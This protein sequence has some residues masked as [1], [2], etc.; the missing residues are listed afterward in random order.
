MPSLT[1]P[2][3]NGRRCSSLP[4]PTSEDGLLQTREIE[5]LDL[6]GRIVVLS[7]CQTASG[8]ILGGE[9]VLSLARAF[10]EAGA[11]AVIGSRWPIRDEDAAS[12][13][14]SVLPAPWSRRVAVGGVAPGKDSGYRH[15]PTRRGMGQPRPSRGRRFPAVSWRSPRSA[16]ETVAFVASAR[17]PRPAASCCARLAPRPPVSSPFGQLISGRAVPS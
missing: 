14:D 6:E 12:L 2:V 3:P 1:R 10:F 11:H 13:F 5:G 9:G 17:S 8:A 15:Q 4:G 16:S 7:A